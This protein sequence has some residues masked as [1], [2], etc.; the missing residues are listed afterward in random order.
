MC[1]KL[2]YTKFRGYLLVP[3]LKFNS[4]LINIYD[5][6]LGQIVIII[7]KLFI[8][9]KGIIILYTIYKNKMK[10]INIHVMAR[11]VHRKL[12]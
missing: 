3:F 8:S 2:I 7:Q 5:K 9:F 1:P 12:Q 6:Q 11:E 10:Y 4:K